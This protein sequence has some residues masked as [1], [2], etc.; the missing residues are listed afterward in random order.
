[1]AAG[2]GKLF[3]AF[4]VFED[5]LVLRHGVE[6]SEILDSASSHFEQGPLS[7]FESYLPEDLVDM[8]DL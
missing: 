5:L 1:M 8:F 7:V 3:H 2:L 6:D 4:H